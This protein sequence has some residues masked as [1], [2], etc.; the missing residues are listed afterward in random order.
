MIKAAILSFMFH[1]CS[2][3]RVL[4]WF[5]C[6]MLVSYVIDAVP[7]LIIGHFTPDSSCLP[8]QQ[9]SLPP[10]HFEK[11]PLHVLIPQTVDH[12]IKQSSEHII[13]E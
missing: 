3:D 10:H 11:S 13:K 2:I 9:A 4:C 6:I 5:Y 12:R 8:V 1:I 7:F